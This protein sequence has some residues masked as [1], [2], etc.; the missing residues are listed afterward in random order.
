MMTQPS[1]TSRSGETRPI[2]TEFLPIFINEN[3]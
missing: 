1:P 3:L 2:T